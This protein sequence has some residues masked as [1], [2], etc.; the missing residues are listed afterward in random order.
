MLGRHTAPK[1]R[2]VEGGMFSGSGT[3]QLHSREAFTMNARTS[4]GWLRLIG[5]IF[6]AIGF[7][8]VAA[9]QN[10]IQIGFTPSIETTAAF[11]AKEEGIFA[12]HNLDVEIVLIALNSTLPQ[13]MFANS[14]QIGHLTPPV[15]LQAVD[16]GL[17]L[18]V[19]SGG[20]VTHATTLKNFGV[21]V[22]NGVNIQSPQDFVGKK[23]GVPGFGATLQVLFRRWLME[24]KVDPK[25]VTFVEVSF[26]TM[27]DV[28]KAGTVD[29][30]VTL[31]PATSRIIN[32][33]TGF[34]LQAYKTPEGVVNTFY[35]STRDWAMKNPVA[36]KALHAA[37]AEGAQFAVSNPD[38]AR[39][40][41]A[42]YTR[43]PLDIVNTLTLPHMDPT[44]SESQL[45]WWLDVMK[46]QNMLQSNI[47]LSKLIQ[48]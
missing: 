35:S 44:I 20:T 24:A 42:K 38:K 33:G 21:V 22:R 40:H 15:F 29:A 30:V 48:R 6:A 17:D 14:L 8:Q 9:A 27:N 1:D 12:K 47:D 10:R 46:K 19:I 18:V 43:L 11:V 37:L 45:A 23:V 28:L 2:I 34:A 32:A 16:G 5:I 4:F 31:E 36:V 39:I 41:V 26:P 13:A 3:E 25:T 7:S